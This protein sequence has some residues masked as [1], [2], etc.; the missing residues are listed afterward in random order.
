[1]YKVSV[2]NTDFITIHR[3]LKLLQTLCKMKVVSCMSAKLLKHNFRFKQVS[4]GFG[5]IKMIIGMP[6]F[7]HK[8]YP[9]QKHLLLH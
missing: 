7:I 4:L 1:M 8:N 6:I 5:N 3:D 2:Q 9:L